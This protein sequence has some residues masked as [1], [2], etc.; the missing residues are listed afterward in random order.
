MKPSAVLWRWLDGSGMEYCRI[1]ERE[2][3]TDVAGA[4]VLSVN[5]VPW[6]IDYEVQADG[7]W[8]TRAVS[9]RTHAAAAE[10][11]LALDVDERGRWRL[12]GQE[13]P[14]LQG[15]V[16]VDLGFSPS[17]NT[18]P[19]RRLHLEIGQSAV[20]DAAWMEFP[21]LVLHRVPQRYTRI[22]EHTYRY[23]NLPTGFTADVNVDERGLVVAYPPGWERVAGVTTSN[24]RAR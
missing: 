15:C 9:M 1:S 3:R 21:S 24:L 20:I 19:I 8:R 2:D 10:R 17:T 7:R 23:D 4:V 5:G 11:A 16:D 6:H 14:D 18:L 13:R 12:N 22:D